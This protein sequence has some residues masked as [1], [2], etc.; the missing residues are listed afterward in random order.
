[1][2][3]V[4]RRV[5]SGGRTLLLSIHQL[6]DAEQGCDRL[7][8]LADGRIR[9]VGTLQEV[10]RPTHHPGA[11]LEEGFLVL[12]L[13]IACARR[14]GLARIREGAA[15][16]HQR[17]RPVDAV[18]TRVPAR[19]LQLFPSDVALQRGEYRSGE[20]AGARYQS[21]TPG[22]NFGPDV[23]IVLRCRHTSVSI[24]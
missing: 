4:L 12:T 15:R 2:M 3:G 5:A 14:S 11:D 21:F 17:S 9:G 20:L 6:R 1:M 7:A 19:R 16:N 24:C 8:L 23:W 18:A 22:R 10:R 13:D